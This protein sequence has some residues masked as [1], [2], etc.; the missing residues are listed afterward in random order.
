MIGLAF[1]SAYEPVCIPDIQCPGWIYPLQTMV[2]ETD[3]VQLHGTGRYGQPLC[4][5]AGMVTGCGGSAI[6]TVV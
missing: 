6:R 4:F 1:G 3:R 2:S 5:V